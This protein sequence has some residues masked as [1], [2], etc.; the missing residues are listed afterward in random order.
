LVDPIEELC[1]GVE[2]LV[3]KVQ[4]KAKTA[5]IARLSKLGLTGVME[6]AKPPKDVHFGPFDLSDIREAR[7]NIPS[8]IDVSDPLELLDFFIPP[9]MYVII[10]ENTNLYAT[11]NNAST[12]R[13]PI[14]SRY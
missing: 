3:L 12:I 14:N 9:K 2:G 13:P 8:N 11:A 1:I 5:E 10:A 7:L 6:E 4:K